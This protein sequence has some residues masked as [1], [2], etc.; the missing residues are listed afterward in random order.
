MNNNSLSRRIGSLRSRMSR[1]RIPSRFTRRTRKIVKRTINNMAETKFSIKTFDT[2]VPLYNAAT[3]GV[4]QDLTPNFP[5][6]I[7]KTN[8]IGSNIQYKFATLRMNISVVWDGSNIK[9]GNEGCY[10]VRT[11]FYQ[12]RTTITSVG[13]VLSFDLL[14]GA[15]NALKG[16]AICTPPL[17]QN[18]RVLN[19]EIFPLFSAYN[20]T[21]AAALLNSGQSAGASV[22]WRHKIHN[23]VNFRSAADAEP[24]NPTD[25]YG[26][27]I[28]LYGTRTKDAVDLDHVTASI[29]G[30]LKIS[31][32]DI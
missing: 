3:Y 7:E 24:Y 14:N 20:K 10:F 31:Y 32:I 5:Q 8:R 4:I 25:Q 17:N 11:V 13:D 29:S 18:V 21:T 26:M 6:G 9:N 19:D 2:T 15:A 22:T 16:S 1:R 23:H 30:C 28:L 27:C 12:K